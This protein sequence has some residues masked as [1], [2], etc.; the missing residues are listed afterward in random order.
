[1]NTDIAI[2]NHHGYWEN[3]LFL[4]PYSSSQT[5][6]LPEGNPTKIPLNDFKIPWTITI[7]PYK[8]HS[9]FPVYQR[10]YVCWRGLACS[11]CCWPGFSQGPLGSWWCDRECDLGGFFQASNMFHHH[12]L[13]NEISRGGW[14]NEISFNISFLPPP[15]IPLCMFGEL[16][17]TI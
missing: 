13:K 17:P 4:R 12:P 3:S 15:Y 11:Q 5:V 1:M 8:S 6:S 7:N 9:S 2:Q 10:V 14:P 16:A